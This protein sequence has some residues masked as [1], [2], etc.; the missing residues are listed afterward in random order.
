MPAKNL[1]SVPGGK[2]SFSGGRR[3]AVPNSNM[4][5]HS[6]LKQGT[7]C[8]TRMC[9]SICVPELNKEYFPQIQYDNIFSQN[10][11]EYGLESLPTNKKS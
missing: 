4:N 8:N 5:G 3:E 9:A 1:H 7:L 11:I 2:T 6:Y 10:Y